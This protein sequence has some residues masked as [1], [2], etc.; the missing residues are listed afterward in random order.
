M[1]KKQLIINQLRDQYTYVLEHLIESSD[2][3][4]MKKEH[5]SLFEWIISLECDD[6]SD[7]DDILCIS[8]VYKQS[9]IAESIRR[10]KEEEEAHRKSIENFKF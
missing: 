8:D 9:Q 1:N 4:A 3:N 5:F 6:E 7:A 10:E 2:A